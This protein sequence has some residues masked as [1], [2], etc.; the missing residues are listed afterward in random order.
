MQLGAEQISRRCIQGV[1]QRDV[2][3]DDFAALRYALYELHRVRHMLKD[4]EEGDHV[5]LLV[6]CS[7]IAQNELDS[8]MTDLPDVRG[9]I[10][11][12]EPG[13]VVSVAPEGVRDQFDDVAR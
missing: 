12:L 11:R 9:N 10:V 8:F 4:I 3:P 13:R 5:D 6:R 2:K 1:V 7:E